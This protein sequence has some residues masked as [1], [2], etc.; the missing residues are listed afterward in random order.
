MLSQWNK[1]YLNFEVEKL[2]LDSWASGT[3]KQYKIYFKQWTTSCKTQLVG[4]SSASIKDGT[5]S[6][7][8]LYKRDLDTQQSILQE[9][10]YQTYSLKEGIEFGKH[11]IVT[12]M[13]KR[14]FRTRPALPRYICIYDAEVVTEFL[15]SLPRWEEITLKWLTLKLVT[16]LALLSARRC[17]TLNSLWIEHMDSISS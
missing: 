8:S 15:K 17:Q 2:I 9:A 4:I 12:R 5:E 13:L 7:L 3:R 14:I 1:N 16:L 6:L 11:P 10:C